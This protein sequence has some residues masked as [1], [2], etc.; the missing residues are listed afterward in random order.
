[1]LSANHAK[2]P[3]GNV[4]VTASDGDTLTFDGTTIAA[5]AKLT[6]NFSFS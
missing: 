6:S 2:A 1:M 3:N 4:V 5:L